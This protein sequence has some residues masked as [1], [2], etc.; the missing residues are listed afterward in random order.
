MSAE[1]HELPRKHRL[2]VQDFHRM[3]EAGIFDEDSRVELIE[4]EIIDMTPIGTIHA[5]AVNRLSNIIKL[6]V[7]S[8]AI[9]S[10]QNPIVLGE[11]SEPEPDIALL[12]PRH[13]FYS[14]AHPRAEDVLLLIEV[15]E[16]SLRYERDVKIPLYARQGVPEVWL[17]DLQGHQ[18]IIHRTPSQGIYRQIETAAKLSGLAAQRLPAFTLDLTGLF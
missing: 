8:A 16:S 13:D 1:A 12:K 2:R 7:G 4:G 18:L 3:G 6:A 14:T 11:R 5:G 10:T 9:V 17:V 15:A